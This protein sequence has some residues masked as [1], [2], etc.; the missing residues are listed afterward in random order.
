MYAIFVVMIL[1]VL[2]TKI[3]TT[4]LPHST[5]SKKAN[6]HIPHHT[7]T[8][9]T[10]TTTTQDRIQLGLLMKCLDQLEESGTLEVASVRQSLYTTCAIAHH[11]PDN[12]VRYVNSHL[13]LPPSSKTHDD[14][15]G[16]KDNKGYKESK[17]DKDVKTDT[18]TKKEKDT[19][20]ETDTKTQTKTETKYD[21]SASYFV[22]RLNKLFWRLVSTT[23]KNPLTSSITTSGKAIEFI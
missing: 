4:Q 19:K 6:H 12:L 3:T 16:E 11:R 9:T 10:T 14:D 2:K 13:S 20:T 18:N 21:D 17:T 15:G 23:N 5:T 7:N 22:V 1:F 8:N